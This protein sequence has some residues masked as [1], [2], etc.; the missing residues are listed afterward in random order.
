MDH[1][2]KRRHQ[3]YREAEQDVQLVGER[4]IDH[5]RGRATI[6][7]D[8]AFYVTRQRLKQHAIHVI[9]RERHRQQAERELQPKHKGD[10]DIPFA[11]VEADAR[12]GETPVYQD[13]QTDDG[14]EPRNAADHHREKLMRRRIE[15]PIDH[16]MRSEKAGEVSEDDD[17]HA[18][19]EQVRAEP[20][21]ALAQHLR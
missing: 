17:D 2:G 20:K 9:G 19:V 18:I 11:A 1:A 6:E 5:Q 12:I 16:P 15:R 8:D 21:L 13:R 7:R 14:N 3:E 10:G 4:H